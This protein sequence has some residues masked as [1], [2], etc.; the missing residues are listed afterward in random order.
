MMLD[1]K[2]II[3]N[4]E[5]CKIKFDERIIH[6]YFNIHRTMLFFFTRKK[7]LVFL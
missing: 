1:Y 4:D 5:K 7:F 3:N 6:M 2:T